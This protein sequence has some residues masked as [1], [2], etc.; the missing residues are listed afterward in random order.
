M[1]GAPTA[2]PED[3]RRPSSVFS[4]GFEK[5]YDAFTPAQHQLLDPTQQ[6]TIRRYDK[7]HQ[8]HRLWQ[9]TI[10]EFF[11]TLI[12][13]ITYF[14]ILYKYSHKTTM[15][16]IE[17]RTFNALVTTNALLLGVN[18][19]ASLRSYAKMLRWRMLS[20]SYRPLAT[21]DL[22]M[23]CD[24]LI[25]VIKLLYKGGNKGSKWPS[26]TQAFAVIWLLINLAAT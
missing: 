18:L 1:A 2:R 21:F 15:S 3:D 23:G 6:S 20:V 19:S 22:V 10:G 7:R 14:V 4:T 24:S 8:R 5:I 17:R 16:N 25:N 13:C 26:R 11:L 9:V 12:L